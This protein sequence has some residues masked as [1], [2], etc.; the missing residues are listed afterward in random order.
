MTELPIWRDDRT[1]SPMS[2]QQPQRVRLLVILWTVVSVVTVM[3]VLGMQSTGLAL[4]TFS[5]NLFFLEENLRGSP[6]IGL[7]ASDEDDQYYEWNVVS[8]TMHKTPTV[9]LILSESLTGSPAIGAKPLDEESDDDVRV[10]DE[11][12]SEDESNGESDDDEEDEEGEEEEDEDEE[13]TT[14]FDGTSMLQIWNGN[15]RIDDEATA[16]SSDEEFYDINEDDLI[17][18]TG[19]SPGMTLAQA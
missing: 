4:Q 11:F 19:T 12:S 5:G 18:S 9:S 3:V 6:A 1:G 10:H 17:D 13:A 16:D 8:K 7:P 2:A 15:Y 14:R